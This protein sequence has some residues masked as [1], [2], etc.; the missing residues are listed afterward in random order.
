MHM[1]SHHVVCTQL[2][3][4]QTWQQELRYLQASA[5]LAR[6]GWVVLL[7]NLRESDVPAYW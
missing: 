2:P 5:Q 7:L 1:F 4:K 3:N 6:S